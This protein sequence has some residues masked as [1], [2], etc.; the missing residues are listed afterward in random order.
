MSPETFRIQTDRGSFDW[1]DTAAC[2]FA[3]RPPA[4]LIDETLSLAD[5]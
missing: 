2:H 1:R 3:I 5:E 4:A